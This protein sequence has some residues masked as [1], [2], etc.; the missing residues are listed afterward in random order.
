M[1]MRSLPPPAWLVGDA[2]ERDVAISSRVR[3]ARNLKGAWFVHHASSDDLRRVADRVDHAVEA[4]GLGLQRHRR[5]T[6]A[7]QEYWMGTRLISPEFDPGL[8][9]RALYLDSD[10][11]VSLMVN[12]ED[13]LRLQALTGGWS[14]PAALRL[15]DFVRERLERHLEWAVAPPWGVLTASP[16]NAGLGVRISTMF[17]LIGLAQ[18]RRL[19]GV[20]RAL[21][22]YG[23]MARGLF[24]ESSRAVGA[25]LQVSVTH[26]RVAEL[27]GAVDVILREERRARAE[28]GRDEL[29]QRVREATD[30]A[31][32]QGELSL[33]D[34][35]RVAAWV[36][37]AAAVDLP[38]YPMGTRAVDGWLARLEVRPAAEPA[39][40]AR[41]RAVALREFLGR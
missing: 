25:F 36:R 23:V 32:A 18:T 3:Y 19:P 16:A 22:E 6:P 15:A 13:H 17:H 4:S 7:E 2:P 14:A 37:W 35:L 20:L 31:V 30:F 38:G 9:G 11:A 12:E 39:L 5:L 26:R 27:V 1:V 10:Q 40:A 33:A 8:T 21:G 34:T 29:T 28:V 41:D 24:G